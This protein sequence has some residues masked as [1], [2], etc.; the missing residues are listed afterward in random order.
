MK[1]SQNGKFYLFKNKL[2]QAEENAEKII[3][4]L[5]QA[6]EERLCHAA[7]LKL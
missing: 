1:R 5:L 7:Y 6:K 2:L 4:L 3:L